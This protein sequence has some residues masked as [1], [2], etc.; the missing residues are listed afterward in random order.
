ME[1]IVGTIGAALVLFAFILNQMN[2]IK[3]DNILYDFI[4]FVGSLLL[5][6]YAAMTGSIPFIILNSV[7]GLFSLKD[8]LFKLVR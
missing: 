2:I 8:V 5:V 4:N 6:I 3:N 7:W 1:V